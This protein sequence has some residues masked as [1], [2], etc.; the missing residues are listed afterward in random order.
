MCNIIWIFIFILFRF[1]L[2]VYESIK[3]TLV[4]SLLGLQFVFIITTNSGSVS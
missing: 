4:M 1:L 3:K 2:F